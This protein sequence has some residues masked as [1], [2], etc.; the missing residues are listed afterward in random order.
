MTPTPEERLP[1]GYLTKE[2]RHKLWHQSGDIL[3]ARS[4]CHH[5]DAAY[6]L[7]EQKDREIARLKAIIAEH[8]YD[9][10]HGELEPRL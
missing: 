1:D 8:I 7:L 2:Q 6:L 9:E 4:L 5:A 10:S 3:T